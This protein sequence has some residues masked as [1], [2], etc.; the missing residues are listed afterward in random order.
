MLTGLFIILLCCFVSMPTW[1]MILGIIV[2]SLN[3][4]GISIKMTTSFFQL[5]KKIDDE[6]F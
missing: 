5:K 1:L 4:L 3:I 2:G 6:D